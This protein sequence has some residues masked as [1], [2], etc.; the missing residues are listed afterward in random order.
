MIALGA[1]ARAIIDENYKQGTMEKDYIK[2]V[3]YPCVVSGSVPVQLALHPTHHSYTN[4]K[5]HGNKPL[6]LIPIKQLP[7]LIGTQDTAHCTA[8]TAHTTYKPETIATVGDVGQNPHQHLASFLDNCLEI[9]YQQ[10]ESKCPHCEGLNIIK[11]GKDRKK[12]NDCSKTFK[13]I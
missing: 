2:S 6:N 10:I 13:G 5:K 7:L 9:P 12:C 4:F 1:S 8:D 11:W 3:A